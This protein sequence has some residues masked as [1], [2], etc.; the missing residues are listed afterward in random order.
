MS[1]REQ[2]SQQL[3]IGSV[4][5]F[6]L[7]IAMWS[8][9]QMSNAKAGATTANEDL[10]ECRALVESIEKL[11]DQPKLVALE[12]SSQNSVSAQVEET[13]GA[14]GLPAEVLRFVEMQ[15]PE[16]IGKS[17]YVNQATRIEIERTSLRQILQLARNLEAG[18]AGYRV[19]DLYLTV[20]DDA[21]PGRELW[22]AEAVL[23][24][25]VFS[26]TTR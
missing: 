13:V 26:P 4:G 15:K 1:D 7:L 16:R 3:L 2:R 12:S 6:L 5:V 25:T 9:G 20:N 21:R 19:R 11:N 23:T 10:A 22:D 17:A 24:Q 8:Y 18:N 14:V